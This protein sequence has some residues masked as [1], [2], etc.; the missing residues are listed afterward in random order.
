MKDKA[1]AVVAEDE[2]LARQSLVEMI[3]E[4]EWLECAG[5]A[6]DGAQVMDM[7]TS[8]H[9]DV[10]FLDV[11]MPLLSGLE[12]LER[13]EYEPLVVFTTA[14]DQYAVPAFEIGAVDYLIKP[15][16]RERFNKALE[17]VRESLRNGSAGMP[18]SARLREI[19]RSNTLKRLFARV[20]DRILPIAI[21]DVSRFKGK[22][23]Y[24]SVHTEKQDFLIA[25]SLSWL[26]EHLDISKFLRIHRSHIVNLD[27]V[28]EMR[29]YEGQRLV[30]EMEDGT[31]IIASRSGSRRLRKL[32]D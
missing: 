9:P 21:S 3:G 2:P 13:L 28:R 8:L 10:L 24:V 14:Y 11:K 31:Q 4:T 23:D 26:E 27:R 20:G 17:R 15:F 22:G 18:T 6:G 29:E 5:E 7:V 16:G 1:T 25:V 12:A 19:G 32:I 30:L